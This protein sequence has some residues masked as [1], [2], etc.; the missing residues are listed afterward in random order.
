[1]GS[2]TAIIRRRVYTRI[3]MAIAPPSPDLRRRREPR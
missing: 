3:K 1:M 2:R